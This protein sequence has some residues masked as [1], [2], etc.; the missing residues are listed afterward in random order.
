[1][2][3]TSSDYWSYLKTNLQ[4]HEIEVAGTSVIVDSKKNISRSRRGSVITSRSRRG[5][6]VT[7]PVNLEVA[8]NG[9]SGGKNISRSRRGSVIT[10]RSRRGSIVTEPVNLEVA[11]NGLSGGNDISLSQTESTC[12]DPDFSAPLPPPRQNIAYWSQA[13]SLFS[14][15]RIKPVR[16]RRRSSYVFLSDEPRQNP[17]LD[18]LS[19]SYRDLQ[20]LFFPTATLA[21]TAD[22]MMKGDTKRKEKIDHP[23]E[24]DTISVIAPN[25]TEAQHRDDKA[26]AFKDL[27]FT[28]QRHRQPARKPAGAVPCKKSTGLL[29]TLL[30]GPIPPPCVQVPL[31]S[32]QTSCADQ[33]PAP[34]GGP[35]THSPVAIPMKTPKMQAGKTTR[36]PLGACSA[37]PELPRQRRRSPGPPPPSAAFSR[38]SR[39]GFAAGSCCACRPSAQ[40]DRSPRASKAGAA[41]RLESRGCFRGTRTARRPSGW[42]TYWGS[43]SPR[44]PPART[45][46]RGGSN[47][48]RWRRQPGHRTG[49]HR[50]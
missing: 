6:I 34:V 32:A 39:T 23:E 20:S 3:S 33:R 16:S 8:Q 40:T 26:N 9:F 12:I 28:S 38:R 10:S 24:R 7:E 45:G 11:P 18:E 21:A 17:R 46:K 29:C 36:S 41:R 27:N 5:S 37:R 35:R 22:N 25:A 15:F 14:S 2:H 19:G 49:R 13:E 4:H 47:Q 44:T 48:P 43:L 50:P 1:M 42:T 30:T 31:Q